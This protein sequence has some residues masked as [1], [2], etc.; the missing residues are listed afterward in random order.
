MP[1]VL[2]GNSR[3]LGRTLKHLPY[4]Q[5]NGHSN[6]LRLHN[7]R[8]V[9]LQNIKTIDSSPKVLYVELHIVIWAQLSG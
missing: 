8:S 6:I 5:R 4:A 3:P 2:P 1:A 9:S 7:Y